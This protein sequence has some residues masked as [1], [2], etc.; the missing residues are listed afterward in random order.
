MKKPA[1]LET[2]SNSILVEIEGGKR[3]THCF[4]GA[5]AGAGTG[6]SSK[7]DGAG[8]GAERPLMPVQDNKS[9]KIAAEKQ[10]RRAMLAKERSL[11]CRR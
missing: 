6:A 9:S 11:S 3:R 2:L 5:G 10:V 8:A 7:E 4:S 1:L